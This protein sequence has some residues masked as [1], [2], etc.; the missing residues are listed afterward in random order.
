VP[1]G[2]ITK[3]DELKRDVQR[4]SKGGEKGSGGIR[5]KSKVSQSIKANAVDEKI[6]VGGDFKICTHTTLQQR[7][8]INT[9][10]KKLT[11]RV[12]PMS[13]REISTKRRHS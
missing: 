7:G 5:G 3:G 12:I 1:V 13:P 10:K 6:R 9:E 4:S 8:E 11:K 2:A